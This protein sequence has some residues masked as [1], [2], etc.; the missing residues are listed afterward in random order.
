MN[1]FVTYKY[2]TIVGICMCMIIH[3]TCVFVIFSRYFISI[4]ENGLLKSSYFI[5]IG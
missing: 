4:Q 1:Y 5:N 2:N 3:N